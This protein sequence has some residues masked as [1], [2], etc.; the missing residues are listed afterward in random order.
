MEAALDELP[1]QYAGMLENVSF[2]I[3]RAVMPRDR[4]RLRLGNDTL[5]GLYEGVPMTER[6]SGY[7]RVLP[8]RITLYWGPLVRDY[9]DEAEL[10]DQVRKTVYH[11]IAHYFGLSDDDLHATRV[12]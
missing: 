3:A 6:T 11:E 8:D 7:D 12:E 2:H 5:Y 9:P 1:E 10:A 4:R